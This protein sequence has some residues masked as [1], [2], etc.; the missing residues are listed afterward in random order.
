VLASLN[1]P[2]RPPLTPEDGDRQAVLPKVVGKDVDANSVLARNPEF[3]SLQPAN[4]GDLVQGAAEDIGDRGPRPPERLIHRT[5]NC[6]P[7]A[8]PERSSEA[9]QYS[10]TRAPINAG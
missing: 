7:A 10:G 6:H 4:F 3:Q 5:A 9:S 1:P 2:R 8:I